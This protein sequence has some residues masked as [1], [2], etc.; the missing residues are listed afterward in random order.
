MRSGREPGSHLVARQVHVDAY[1]LR[2]APAGILRADGSGIVVV[3]LHRAE[4][5]AFLP[6]SVRETEALIISSP[7]VG[8][9]LADARALYGD[10]EFARFPR[11]SEP[12]AG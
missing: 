6:A 11:I 12:L 2:V 3:P 4:Q 1:G 9:G 8:T 10:Y 5:V 7:L